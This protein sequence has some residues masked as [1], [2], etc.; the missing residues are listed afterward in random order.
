MV[1]PTL[2]AKQNAHVI[3][4]YKSGTE[5]VCKKY[6]NGHNN[7]ILKIIQS[8]LNLAGFLHFLLM[9]VASSKY[10][11]VYCD[12]FELEGLHVCGKSSS[13]CILLSVETLQAGV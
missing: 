3:I 2:T 4:R 9:F 10:V 5:S 7:C 11:A 6:V 12:F 1:N 13:D 8:L